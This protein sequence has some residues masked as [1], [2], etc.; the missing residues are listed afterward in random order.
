MT[1]QLAVSAPFIFAVATAAE[2]RLK[3]W[4]RTPQTSC[5][6]ARDCPSAIYEYSGSH[7]HNNAI[8]SAPSR[9]FLGT[10]RPSPRCPWAERVLGSN[11]RIWFRR[12]ETRSEAKSGEQ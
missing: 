8:R 5:A 9:S 10:P 3:F 7:R 4:R 6:A 1:K 12:G 11:R 2:D